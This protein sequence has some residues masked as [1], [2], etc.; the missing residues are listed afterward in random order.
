MESLSSSSPFSSVVADLPSA[1]LLQVLGV[2]LSSIMIHQMHPRSVRQRTTVLLTVPT[3]F[4]T[5]PPKYQELIN[6]PIY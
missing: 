6:P 5:A 2:I 3:V 4:S 1:L